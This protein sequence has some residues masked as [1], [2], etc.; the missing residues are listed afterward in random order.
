LHFQD[1]PDPTHSIKNYRA[2]EAKLAE[3]QRKEETEYRKALA[4][5]DGLPQI[6]QGL[7]QPLV[8]EWKG[9]V[10]QHHGVLGQTIRGFET[11]D[12]TPAFYKGQSLYEISVDQTK[13]DAF[14][15]AL[16]NLVTVNLQIP[17][18]ALPSYF[19]YFS[20]G[21]LNK[22]SLDQRL[23]VSSVDLGSQTNINADSVYCLMP[24]ERVFVCGGSWHANVYLIETWNGTVH[25]LPDMRDAR[26]WHGL[27]LLNGEMMVFGG[28]S[29][30]QTPLAKCESYNLVNGRWS[31]FGPMSQ[32]RCGITP[33]ELKFMIYIAGGGCNTVDRYDT[34]ARLFEPLNLT[35][36]GS[37]WS[38]CLRSGSS[39]LI[40]NTGLITK[41]DIQGRECREVESSTGQF[42]S[43]YSV[44]CPLVSDAKAY[45][46]HP[47]QTSKELIG[48]TLSP[49]GLKKLVTVQF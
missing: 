39:L 32:A 43:W 9:K 35:L 7:M 6:L 17:G 38:M 2:A 34:S 23:A 42:Q 45:F 20:P 44:I 21:K 41:Y 22:V 33:C 28:A 5:I 26:A 19:P 27:V 16:R 30:N 3:L 25:N 12:T 13:K 47:Y 48:M 4:D 14:L 46:F 24:D 29:T 31:Q 37:K 8:N 49:M 11:S 15:S 36:P 40:M 1:L 18:Q 10:A